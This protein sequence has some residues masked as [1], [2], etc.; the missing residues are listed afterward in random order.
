MNYGP[1][2]PRAGLTILEFIM[3]MALAIV[4][5]FFGCAILI[6]STTGMPA[7]PVMESWFR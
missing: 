4:M 5:A 2:D 3:V 6:E 1:C 7:R